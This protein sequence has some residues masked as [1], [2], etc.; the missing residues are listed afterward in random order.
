M[1][2]PFPGMDPFIESHLWESFHGPFAVE[3]GKQLN[4]QLRP[5]YFALVER[6]VMSD[7]P[8]EILVSS[9]G[10]LPDVSVLRAQPESFRGGVAVLDAPVKMTAP[11]P[12]TMSHYTVEV[13]DV[14]E[15]ELVT[16]IEILSPANK[17]G[18]GRLEYLEKRNE[19]FSSVVNLVEI[20]LLHNGQRP[21]MEEAFPDAPYFLLVHPFRSRPIADV[22]PIQLKDPL[23]SFPV[24]LREETELPMVD[25]QAALTSVYDSFNFDIII[26][27]AG[28][29]P[30]FLP[31]N[32]AAWV[33]SL[34]HQRLPDAAN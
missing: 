34:L 1:P 26:D 8:D 23:P 15:R 22:W 13:R 17:R 27:Y 28:P 7:T 33:E 3:I 30:D 18:K 5:S 24:P 25:L 2:S 19:V 20:D 6:R 10:G 21:P 9:L 12:R 31:Q 14:S 4:Q 29:A 11:V 16:A 32:E